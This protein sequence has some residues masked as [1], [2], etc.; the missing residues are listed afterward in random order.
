MNNRNAYILARLSRDEATRSLRSGP[1]LCLV[2]RAQNAPVCVPFNF[3]S[4]VMFFSPFLQK[5]K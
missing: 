3:K 1:A 4:N 5:E 2:R